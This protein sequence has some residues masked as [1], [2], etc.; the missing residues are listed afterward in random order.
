[1]YQGNIGDW[2]KHVEFGRGSVKRLGAVMETI[3]AT[4]AVVICGNTVATGPMLELV[5]AGLGDRFAGVWAGVKAHT[6]LDDVFVAA[7]EV[8]NM[9]ADVVISVGG[10]SAMDAAKGVVIALATN[11]DFDPYT[12][13]YLD[14]GMERASLEAVTIKHIAVPTTAG[15]ASDVMPTAGIRDT[16]ANRKLLFWDKALTPDATVLDPEMAVFANAKLTAATGMTAVARA[17]ESLYS[18]D[19]NPYATGIALHSARL[20]LRNLP[21]V[22]ENPNDLDARQNCQFACIMAGTAAI[23][24]MVSIVHAIG[25]VIGGRYGLQHGISHGI[26]LAPALR[27]ML[28]MAGGDAHKYVLEALGCEH[29]D[30]V[31]EAANRAADAITALMA[32]LPSPRRLSEVGV[33]QEHIA[34]IASNTMGDYMMGNLPGPLSEEDVA[35]LLREA[36]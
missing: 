11:G 19:R 26:M 10:G 8:R 6:P 25:H 15:S 13:K 24:S 9:N 32:K 12:I 27:K 30:S 36:L 1:M 7:K 3:G 17:I 18:K 34:E 33:T 2:P 21:L 23:N 35:A 22:V 4:R 29:T 28:P 5:K 20:M 14:K 31:E 16:R